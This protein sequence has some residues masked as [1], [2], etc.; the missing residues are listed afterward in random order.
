MEVQNESHPDRITR[1]HII[2]GVLGL[3]T[4]I[5]VAYAVFKNINN[6]NKGK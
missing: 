4:T 6:K 5:A 3:A 1:A 2:M